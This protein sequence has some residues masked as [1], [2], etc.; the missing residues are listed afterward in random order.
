M[1][2]DCEKNSERL[3]DWESKFLDSISRRDFLTPAQAET[4]EKIWERV[5]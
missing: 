1:I 3:T 4:L 2:S 5:T